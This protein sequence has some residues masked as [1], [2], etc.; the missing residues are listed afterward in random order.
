MKTKLTLLVILTSL[1][2]I[3]Q[4]ITPA[5]KSELIYKIP[6][7]PV[8]TLVAIDPDCPTNRLKATIYF[9]SKIYAMTNSAQY[10]A[11][12]NSIASHQ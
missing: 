11:L 12:S 7:T 5:M 6:R 4:D 1:I 2:A 8:Q 10:V 3:A 9:N